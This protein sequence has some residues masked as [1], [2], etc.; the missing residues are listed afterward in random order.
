MAEA[1]KQGDFSVGPD[2]KKRRLVADSWYIGETLGKGG[3]GF[4]KMGYHK[5]NGKPFA[6]KF[7]RK[8]DSN[9]PAAKQQ[10]QLVATEINC[11][12]RVQNQ[13]VLKLFAYRTS[14]VYPQQ[15][16]EKLNTIMLVL[17]LARGGDLFDIL[18]YTKKLELNLARTY[19]YQMCEGLNAIH[20]AGICHRDLKPQ[21]L[22]LN[23]KFELKITDFGLSKIFEDPAKKKVMKTYYAGTQGYQAPEQILKRNF[24][25]KCDVF[26]CGVILF[27]LITG[28][29]PCHN[30]HFSDPFYKYIAQVQY[31]KFWLKHRLN[32]KFDEET[33]DIMN[34]TLCYQPTDRYTVKQML[35]HPWVQSDKKLSAEK[36][37]STMKGLFKTAMEAKAKDDKKLLKLQQASIV[38]KEDKRDRADITVVGKLPVW[39]HRAIP[40]GRAFALKN[41]DNRSD[42]DLTADFLEYVDTIVYRQD[43]DSDFH[44]QECRLTMKIHFEMEEEDLEKDEVAHVNI[45]KLKNET[46]DKVIAVFE[47]PTHLKREEAEELYMKHAGSDLP[48]WMEDIDEEKAD[49]WHTRAIMDSQVNRGQLSDKFKRDFMAEFKCDED[50]F[51]EFARIISEDPIAFEL[52]TL[53]EWLIPQCAD[54]LDHLADLENKEFLESKEDVS[55]YAD[56][57]SFFDAFNAQNEFD[58]EAK[59]TERVVT[60]EFQGY[61]MEEES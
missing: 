2:G 43:G 27:I 9:D 7:I 11:L 59:K 29:P 10:A 31:D 44:P 48:E 17:E 47:F 25:P 58:A 13:Y 55:D 54:Y 4:V 36:L 37:T 3:F 49:E 15:S 18:Y 61:V 45:Y 46:Q 1:E 24:T 5:K 23:S 51:S 21:N 39:E 33:R 56:M 32:K 19:F 26:S 12:I 8:S 41:P 22:L 57:E 40:R 28:Y 50:N 38:G 52:P 34:K 14:C 20:S 53:S 35:D 60:M 42:E 6:L 30:A 16:G